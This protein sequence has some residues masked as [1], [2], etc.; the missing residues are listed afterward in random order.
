MNETDKDPDIWA[1]WL[2]HKRHA[3]DPA[4]QALVRADA[5][6]YADRV[7]DLAQIQPGMTLLDVGSGDGVVAFRAIERLGAA[8]KAVLTDVSPELLARAQAEARRRGVHQQCTFWRCAAD[9][10]SDIPD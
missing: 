5:L 7:L 1:D 9:S 4:F 2:L 6:T 10:L 3:H 8:L